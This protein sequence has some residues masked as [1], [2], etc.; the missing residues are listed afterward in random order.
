[1]DRLYSL[2]FWISFTESVPIPQPNGFLNLHSQNR[3]STAKKKIWLW[4]FN[5]LPQPNNFFVKIIWLWNF[6]NLHSQKNN[7]A[8]EFYKSPQPKKIFGCGNLYILENG[9]GE[10]KILKIKKW[11][12]NW[13]G[14]EFL[15]EL[16]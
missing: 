7:L 12:W 16:G 6:L 13:S 2:G 3:P 14:L 10:L 11:L 1:M 9:C 15:Y 5:N 4:R 8:V